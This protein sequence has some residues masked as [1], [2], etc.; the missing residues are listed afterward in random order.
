[1]CCASSSIAPPA[2]SMPRRSGLFRSRAAFHEGSAASSSM[3]RK[4]LSAEER[5]RGAEGPKTPPLLPEIAGPAVVEPSDP[6]LKA[7]LD[8]A[9]E[10]PPTPPFR[11]D[12]GGR[13]GARRQ[14]DRRALC[15]RHRRRYAAARLLHDQVGGQRADRHPHAAGPRHA[16]DARADTGMARRRR[17]AARDR[18]RASHAHDHGPRSRRN[19]FRLRSI[20]PDVIC[21]TTWPPTRSRPR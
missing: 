12:Q 20:Q 1:M 10:E 21:T 16:L 2:P 11:Q 14:G 9:F 8:H 6:A 15:G 17:S 5:H 13:R 4:S 19:Q 18:G 7:A 3:D